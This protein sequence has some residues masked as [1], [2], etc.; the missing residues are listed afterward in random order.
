[1]QNSLDNMTPPKE[2]VRL[3]QCSCSGPPRSPSPLP[4]PQGEG[5]FRQSADETNGSGID[6][7]RPSL[8]PLAGERVRVRGNGTTLH[9]PPG[10][11]SGP[12][13]RAE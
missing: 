6:D 12:S 3:F 8:F 7:R 5:D 4:S 13:A 1:M 10:A 2:A 11:V 9:K